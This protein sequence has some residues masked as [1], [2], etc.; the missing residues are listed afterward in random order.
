MSFGVRLQPIEYEIHNL[1]G[2]NLK[3]VLVGRRP[4]ADR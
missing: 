4:V 1:S 2:T 3:G